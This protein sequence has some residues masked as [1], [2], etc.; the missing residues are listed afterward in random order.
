MS[1][2][3]KKQKDMI[4]D[5]QDNNIFKRVDDYSI[6]LADSTKSDLANGNI[7][8]KM[9]EDIIACEISFTE[10]EANKFISKQD[11][12]I[13]LMADIIKECKNKVDKVK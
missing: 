1:R 3:L 5:L 8:S 4:N 11:D 13:Q 7:T 6:T 9:F 2:Y 10:V 12:A